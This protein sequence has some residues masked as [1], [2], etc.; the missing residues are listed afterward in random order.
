MKTIENNKD[1]RSKYLSCNSESK[2]NMTTYNF[3]N[4]KKG[5]K[6]YECSNIGIIEIYNIGN[7][8]FAQ[9]TFYRYGKT[10]N[11]FIYTLDELKEWQH[12]IKKAIKSDSASV[13]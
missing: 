3:I 9:Y 2:I 1:N 10:K 7:N 13:V 4:S 11:I 5:I 8:E 6:Y 12:E